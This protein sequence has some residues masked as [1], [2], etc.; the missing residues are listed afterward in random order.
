MAKQHHIPVD[1]GAL[2]AKKKLP[3]VTLKTSIQEYVYLILLT[4]HGEWRYD[5]DFHCLLWQKDFEQ[6]DN[7]NIW[8]DQVKEDIKRT[9]RT[10]EI[11]LRINDVDV[12][13]DELQELNKENKVARIRNR[14]NIR[15]K[16]EIVQSGENFDEKFSM[17]F[18]PITVI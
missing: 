7:L 3:N 11:R 5:N 16:G 9:V 2:L 6:T 4:Q 17:F 1:F 10:Y 18:G 14:L 13:R 8:L 15:V 12:Q